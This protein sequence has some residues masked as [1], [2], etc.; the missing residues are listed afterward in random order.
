MSSELELLKQRI[1]EL[2]VKNNKLEAE[3]AELRK[4][5]TE[6]RDLRIKLSVSDAEI[7]ELKRRNIEFLRAN[8]EYNERRDAKNAKLRATIGELKSENAGLR[9]RITKVEQRQMLNDNTPNDNT[10]NN[11]SSNFNSGAVHHEKSSQEKGMDIFLDGVDKKIVGEDI[12]RRNKEKKLQRESANQDITPEPAYVAETNNDDNLDE[13][14]DRSISEKSELIGNFVNKIHNFH[15][16]N[17]DKSIED[18]RLDCDLSSR[19]DLPEDDG[20]TVPSE[21][22]VERDLMQQLSVPSTSIDTEISLTPPVIDK[23]QQFSVTAECI[24]YMF[25]KAVRSG[26]EEIL[27]WYGFAESYDK[28]IN[29]ICTINKVKINTAK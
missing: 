9:D 24:V 10:P 13:P 6:I 7:A 5:N 21:Q 1:T 27:H 20:F 29:E 11:N 23:K 16:R 3:N 28:R 22:V 4:E 14:R 19:K 18:N 2:E 8:E 25:R 26:Y 17:I 12:R 15:D